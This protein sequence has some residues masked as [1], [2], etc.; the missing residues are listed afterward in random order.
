MNLTK[1][2]KLDIGDSKTKRT[3]HLESAGDFSGKKIGDKL[4]GKEI[5]ENQQLGDYEF[6]ITGLS[7]SAGF[8]S[9][10]EVEGTGRKRVLL[11]R[12][13]GMKKK[14]P[15]GLRLRR[16]V[17]GNT[18]SSEINQINLKVT[19]QGST[20]LDQV[21]KKESKEAAEEQ[22]EETKAEVKQ[23]ITPEAKESAQPTESK[24]L[25]VNE[26]KQEIT[27]KAEESAQPQESRDESKETIVNEKPEE[28]KVL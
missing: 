13:R 10:A 26:K 23:E 17:G 1:M 12:G 4:E 21:F 7:D 28:K 16:T 19:K 11:T 25:N 8:P 27:P 5:K 3:Y 14:K 18:I 24:E 6:L 15:K 20:S 9:L 2:V 22:K